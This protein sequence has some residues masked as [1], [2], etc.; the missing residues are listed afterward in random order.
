MVK[1]GRMMRV[2]LSVAHPVAVH[3]LRFICLPLMAGIAAGKRLAA[4]T[5]KW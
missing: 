5:I 3:A 2:G 1:C 4:R